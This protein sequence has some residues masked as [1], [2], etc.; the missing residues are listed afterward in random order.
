MHFAKAIIREKLPLYHI[1]SVYLYRATPAVFNLLKM[2]QGRTGFEKT[3][4]D[5]SV[6]LQKDMDERWA[7]FYK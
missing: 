1:P 3:E 5:D 2:M 6:I 7:R 4:T